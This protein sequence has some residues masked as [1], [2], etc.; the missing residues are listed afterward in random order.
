MALVNIV[1]ALALAE[2]L[3][4]GFAVGRARE[5]YGIKAPATTG[6]QTFECYYRVQMNTL[7]VLIAFV[8]ALW[9]FAYYVSAQW[10]AVLG[11]V[12]IVGRLVY[13]RAYVSDPAKRN[14]GFLLS[15]LPVAALIVGG[16][17]GAT[18]AA[19]PQ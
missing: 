11:A 13:F 3:Y 8:P 19:W 5:R 14:L 7:E 10:A 6:H 9:L 2:Y 15:I 1:L 4:F 12:F 17:I 18:R 16:L